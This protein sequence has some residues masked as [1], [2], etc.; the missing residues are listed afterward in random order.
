MQE[1][2]GGRTEDGADG[3]GAG[4]GARARGEGV[5]RRGDWIVERI[6]ELADGV[7]D[8]GRGD[9]DDESTG[10]RVGE[11]RDAEIAEHGEIHLERVGRTRAGGVL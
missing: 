5:V 2:R 6:S 11:L 3:I 8:A 4:G 7:R 10:E 1:V 9:K